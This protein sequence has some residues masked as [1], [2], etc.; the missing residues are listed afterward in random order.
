MKKK[1][2]LILFCFMWLIFGVSQAQDL[3]RQTTQKEFNQN[4]YVLFSNMKTSYRIAI[5]DK[6]SE[7]ERWAAFEL[8]HWLSE[9]SG[10]Y[11]PIQNLFQPHEGPQIVLGYNDVIKNKTGLAKPVDLDESY[12]YFSSEADIFIY[13][14]GQRG[15]MYGVMAFLENEFGCRWYTPSVTLIPKR[16]ESRFGIYEHAESP[17]IRVRNDFYFEAFD[18]VWAARNKMNGRMTYMDQPGGVDAYWAVHTFYPLMP[19]SE[20]YEKH[21]E[22]YSLIDGKRIY[23]R[24]QLCLSNPDV[25]RIITERVKNKMRES[26]EYLI[27]SVSQNDWRNPCQ[28]DKCQAI[29][30]KEEAESGIMIWF[31]NQIAKS[32]EKE[33]PDKFI[34]TLAYQYTRTPPKKVRP[35]KNVVVRLCP[36][37]A[38]VSHD[39]KSCPQNQ[40]F[41]QDMKVW[42]SIAPHLYIWDYVVNFAHYIMPYPN[43]NVLQPNIKTFRENNAIGIM[44]QAAYQSRGGEFSELKSYLISRLLWNPVCNVEEVISDFMYGYYGRS[45]KYVRQYFDLLN[46]LITPDT[47]MHI[48]LKPDDKIFSK[49]LVEAS[50]LIFEKAE[51]VADNDEILMRVQMT[52]LPIL[53]L[54]CKRSPVIARNDGTYNKFKLIAERENITH[55]AEYRETIESFNNF[56]ENAK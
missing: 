51:K 5:D 50:L 17:G 49:N 27:Y 56:V 35:Q 13:G 2:P 7:S 46:I 12:H 48:G 21:P 6:A 11:F 30:K 44:E 4:E 53:Y 3:L 32:V 38:C 45:G 15:T 54:K 25:L 18:P 34:G 55:Y 8:Q 42:S 14:G 43:F 24:A 47:H 19:P 52:S 33:F 10:I 31:V 39:L 22:Y 26:P 36:I 9:I 41:M 29:V 23:E 40:S 28:C 1:S 16:K 20:F 37:E